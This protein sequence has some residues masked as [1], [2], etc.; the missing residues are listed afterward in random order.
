MLYLIYEIMDGLITNH[1]VESQ[2]I[3]D[4]FLE[5]LVNNQ[6]Y[7]GLKEMVT[8]L[9]EVDFNRQADN[10]SIEDGSINQNKIS[11]LSLE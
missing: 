3:F 5:K 7:M 6:S 1:N 10:S 8:F 11:D 4:E 9:F 2:L